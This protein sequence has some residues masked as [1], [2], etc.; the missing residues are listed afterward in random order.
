MLDQ[1]N[2]KGLFSQHCNI[3]IE[4]MNKKETNQRVNVKTLISLKSNELEF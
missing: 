4:N 1:I 2:K 3:N